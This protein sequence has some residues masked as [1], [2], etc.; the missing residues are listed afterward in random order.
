MHS[1]FIHGERRCGKRW[2][3]KG[4]DWDGNDFFAAR[5]CIEDR[6]SADRTERERDPCAFISYSYELSALTRDRDGLSRK[7]CLRAEDAAGPTL[8]GE[9]VADR[10]AHRLSGDFG[11]ELAATARGDSHFSTGDKVWASRARSQRPS[12]CLRY[13]VIR[14]PASCVAS[15]PPRDVTD[16]VSRLRV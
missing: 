4:A 8:A 6:G 2:I 3:S 9:A 12:G 1:F 15:L 11:L 16:N 5:Q 10:Y 13:T 7:P 14:C